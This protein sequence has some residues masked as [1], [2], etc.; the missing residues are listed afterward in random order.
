MAPSFRRQFGNQRPNRYPRAVSG[1]RPSAS[2]RR[3]RERSEKKSASNVPVAAHE[4]L[5]PLARGETVFSATPIA[6]TA[7]IGDD[8]R[9]SG[10]GRG[11]FRP[12]ARVAITSGSVRRADDGSSC[13]PSSGV[14]RHRAFALSPPEQRRAYD[15]TP[16]GRF[17]ARI[18]RAARPT[19]PSPSRFRSSST[20]SR[21]FER[22]FRSRGDGPA[23]G[24][25][26]LF[27]RSPK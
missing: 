24:V 17:V 25:P 9:K 19:M 7:G 14:T 4:R 20:G 11:N 2:Q 16:A 5:R 22:P 15:I 6:T 18:S 23:E 1:V 8:R 26:T 12:S 3:R 21:S 27:K 10:G 13:A